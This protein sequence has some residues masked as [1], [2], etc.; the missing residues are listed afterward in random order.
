MDGADAKA[1]ATYNYTTLTNCPCMAIDLVN[2][3]ISI[4]SPE[5]SGV[6]RVDTCDLEGQR[7]RS[8][9]L[10]SRKYYPSYMY[11]FE[12]NLIWVGRLFRS[13]GASRRA[14]DVLRKSWLRHDGINFVYKEYS[15]IS[16]CN[17]PHVTGL[18]FYDNSPKWANSSLRERARESHLCKGVPLLSKTGPFRCACPGG[19]RPAVDGFSCKSKCSYQ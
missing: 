9:Y 3:S 15:A 1:I 2:L 6:Y 4:A 8:A 12:G 5:P 18:T 16:N 7:F 10:A 17:L 13:N 14:T 19:T 11:M